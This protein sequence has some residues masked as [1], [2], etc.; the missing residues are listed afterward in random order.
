MSERRIR[1]VTQTSTDPNPLE[2]DDKKIGINLAACGMGMP[3]GRP[4]CL[5]AFRATEA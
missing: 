1:A 2:D 4:G 5:S 3:C